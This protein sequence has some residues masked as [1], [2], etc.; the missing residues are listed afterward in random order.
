MARRVT[1]KLW[2]SGACW[3]ALAAFATL[4]RGFPQVGSG[5][6]M[7]ASGADV[8]IYTAAAPPPPAPLAGVTVNVQSGAVRVRVNNAGAF[9]NLGQVGAGQTGVFE[10]PFAK[11]NLI[12][13][14]G[15]PAPASNGTFV[16]R[17]PTDGTDP[18]RLVGTG[19]L[20][21]G[22]NY[23]SF[24]AYGAYDA[25][26]AQTNR[27]RLLVVDLSGSS[28]GAT[29]TSSSATGSPGQSYVI[30]GGDWGFC[31]RGISKFTVSGSGPVPFSVYAPTAGCNTISGISRAQ[32]ANDVDSIDVDGQANLRVVLTNNGAGTV[33]LTYAIGG[34]TPTPVTVAPGASSP[35][36]AGLLTEFEWTYANPGCTVSLAI[37]GN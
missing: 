34:G 2:V 17:A 12:A 9:G 30:D 24:T 15:M 13:N 6:F 19:R 21:L 5:P 7:L 33:T 14:V 22:G 16:V 10:G 36:I 31:S 29:V 35:P 27:A 37:T 18:D 3:A 20:M 32:T 26:G 23:P 25:A 8:D 11:V 1:S 4:A 28:Q